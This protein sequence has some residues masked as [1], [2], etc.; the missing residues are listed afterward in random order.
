MHV[1]TFIYKYDKLF[2]CE[3]LDNL[4]KKVISFSDEEH[5][6]TL[7]DLEIARRNLQ[8]GDTET[9]NLFL[10][11]VLHC[12]ILKTVYQIAYSI[13]N[14]LIRRVYIICVTND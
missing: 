2:L 12:T 1:C 5:R 8:V 7:E 4:H 13:L 11:T 14:M 6:K 9:A 10:K 3:S